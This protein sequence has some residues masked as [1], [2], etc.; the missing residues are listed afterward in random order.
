MCTGGEKR[1]EREART[2]SMARL[3]VTSAASCRIS[4]G[5]DRGGPTRDRARGMSP[6]VACTGLDRE[7]HARARREGYVRS[8][9]GAA[10]ALAVAALAI[11][12]H[13]RFA[14]DFVTDGTTSA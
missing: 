1:F 11:V 7:L 4:A 14:R 2:R 6:V 13:H 3:H 12:H 10:L 8:V 9:P 5:L